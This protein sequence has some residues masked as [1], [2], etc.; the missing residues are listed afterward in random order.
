MNSNLSA[1]VLSAMAAL[2]VLLPNRTF[3]VGA[4]TCARMNDF[5]DHGCHGSPGCPGGPPSG[6]NNP[7]GNTSS[8]P[9]CPPSKPPAGNPDLAAPDGA[10]ASTGVT[11][12]P[13]WWVSEPYINL[14]IA[15]EPLSYRMSSG[16]DMTFR[17]TYR[18]NYMLPQP[19]QVPNWY[20]DVVE[21]SRNN[22][23]IVQPYFYGM[24]QYSGKTGYLV[25][26]TNAT[27]THNWMEFIVLWDSEW[28]NDWYA[29]RTIFTHEPYTPYTDSY[30]AMAFMPDGGT[31]Y[32]TS[33]VSGQTLNAST[34]LTDPTSQAQLQAFPTNN[35]PTPFYQ[36]TADANGTFWGTTTNG[37]KLTYPDGSVDVFGL[38]E[39]I[40][41]TESETGTGADSTAYALLTERVD[42]QGRVTQLGYKNVSY[43]NACKGNVSFHN[44]YRLAYVVDPDGR[45]NTFNYTSSQETGWQLENIQDQFGQTT[46]F[47]YEGCGS[48]QAG[49]LTGITD[50]QGNTSTFTYQSGSN[51]LISS[52]ITPYGTNDFYYE[53][54]LETDATNAYSNRCIYVTEPE[55]A[56]QLFAYIHNTEGA[57]EASATAPVVPG[58]VFD[59]GNGSG[60]D[61]QLY[62]RNSFYFDRRQTQ[63][64]S[65]SITG[66]LPGNLTAAVAALSAS[67]ADLKKG[68]MQ[69]WLLGT[70]NISVMETLSS[71]RDPSPDAEG[72]TE[73]ERTWYAYQDIDTDTYYS[74][75]I[76]AIAR[77]LPNGSNQYIRY[78]Y[79]PSAPWVPTE[80]AQ[81][82]TEPNGTVGELATYFSYISPNFIDVVGISNS[83]GEYVKMG[84]NGSHE[85]TSVTNSLN[86]VTQLSYDSTSKNLTGV[87][88]YS[89]ASIGLTYSDAFLSQISIQPENKAINF[90]S[91][92]GPNPSV[93]HV[94]ANGVP[95]L[96][97]TN[98]WDNLNRVTGIG[99]PDGTT[100][101]NVY[102]IL[103]LGAH[104]DRLGNWTYYTHDGLQHL[105]TVTNALTNVTTYTWCDCGALTSIS[106]ALGNV[107]TF[108]YNNQSLLTN[109][110]YADGSSLNWQYDLI[111]RMTNE[112]DGSGSY[113]DLSY[114]NQGL[115]T[116]VSNPIGLV[117]GAALDAIGRPLMV[118]NV[119]GVVH[120]NTFDLLN[121]ILTRSWTGG[122]TES[123]G[124]ATNGLVA[125]TNQDSQWT[126]FGRDGAERPTAMTNVVQTTLLGWNGLD[127][128]SSL[129]DG[130]N[131]TTSWGYN[132]YGWIIGKTNTFGTAVITYRE[133]ADGHVTNRWMMGTNTAYKFDAVGNLTGVGYPA[134]S[135]T[136]QYDSINELT[137]LTDSFGTTAFTWTKNRQLAG[138]SGP[139]PSDGIAY[140]YSQGH[141]I[142]LS[143]SQPV[144]NWTQSYNYDSAWRMTNI[145][146]PAG[147]F[148][149]QYSSAGQDLVS[150]V[151][152]P[153]A[154]L[155]ANSYDVLGR[156]TGTSLV[157]SWG[158]TLDGY[159]YGIDA[160]GLRTNIT[161]DLGM[162]TNI[163]SANYD[164][165]GQLTGWNGQE[166][167]GALRHNEQLGY[168]IDAAGNIHNRTNDVFLQVFNAD[169]Q[170]QLT[171]VSYSGTLTYSGATPAP[172]TNI[173]INGVTAQL[174]GDLTFAAPG[175]TLNNGGNTFTAL[176][177]NVY[178]LTVTNTVVAT[179]SNSVNLQ[180]DANGNLTNDGLRA[181]Q[182]NAENQ[183]T[184]VWVAGQ[185][186]VGFIYDG[187]RRRRIE[188]DSTWSGS[189]V[190]TNEI[191]YVY[192]GNVVIQERDTNSNPVAAYTR[193]LDLS[194]S[195]QGAG[196]VGGLL[197]RTETNGSYFF[198]AD[199]GGNITAMLDADQNVVTR[200]EY[201]G[202]GRFLG[203]WGRMA[204]T[205]RYRFSSKEIIPQAGIY[206]YGYRFYDPNFGRW[207]NRDPIGE[208]GD[209]NL[210]NFS[211]NSPVSGFDI[212]GLWYSGP[213]INAA[214][215]AAEEEALGGGP[216]DPVADV[217]ALG[218]LAIGLATAALTTSFDPGS[219][220]ATQP[221]NSATSPPAPQA[222]PAS[223]QPPNKPPC[224]PKKGPPG[225]PGDEP[226]NHH[227]LPQQF[228]PW[229]NARGLNPE[230]YTQ[231]MPMQWHRGEDIGIHN[232]GYNAD[233]QSFIQQYPDA[234]PQQILQQLNY[235]ENHYGF[236]P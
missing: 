113:L 179:Y 210:Y 81:S 28:E 36:G 65:S 158:H 52:L 63:A 82:V 69:H 87:S 51:G 100:V 223:A 203:M 159:G 101:S 138:E 19:D 79:S 89:G 86:Q 140:G 47:S 132:Q 202:F 112:F 129:T 190:K 119:N 114:D 62:H 78:V 115:V 31:Y 208:R 135:I 104:K 175:L 170:N 14:H 142:S 201:D 92:A 127:E 234:T 177:Q 198:H 42:P 7:G 34:Q 233:W 213:L 224:P 226:E 74:D 22:E 150:G 102:A 30:E 23:V 40:G 131:H 45:T 197:A 153:N 97:Q 209:F 95:D 204:S 128:L 121:H 123:F 161:R 187:L 229:F 173:T 192:D 6:Q 27:W 70:D 41:N 26:M 18:Q 90:N 182:Y 216:E 117:W 35:V 160:L 39:W 29:N 5:K 189:W 75:T 174:Y 1:L 111:G 88:T 91:Y 178:G 48:S 194:L 154:A 44:F 228:A 143:L 217:G 227:R 84:Y 12:M 124:Y 180:F 4:C 103:D 134:S 73:G 152:L 105:I 37:L 146:S 162:T 76:T 72:T 130:L 67:S 136:L 195:L 56:S 219:S 139:W 11:G 185:W 55:G 141:L 236:G 99:Y 46:T 38:T 58:S 10:D 212:N 83:V 98:S 167:G 221:Q 211:A 13:R 20:T 215:Y 2:M 49:W 171:N 122:G 230:D 137:N 186:Q 61:A 24:R 200:Y 188:Q 220:P 8:C 214:K 231:D 9:T 156:L 199:G 145:T 118:T 71:E 15:D 54:A 235:L 96:W 110:D 106:N 165:I 166:S 232:Q 181:F 183:L 77:I 157:N 207:L 93:I 218:T 53:E 126:H 193:G 64:L 94:T 16:K 108:S 155:I 148:G 149:Y 164:G 169:P 151:T 120:S 33:D 225:F 206:Y 32:F 184:N 205:N 21:K 176:A 163:V 80:N 222:Q 168:A 25:G 133:D 116:T 60:T 68:R 172:A 125:Y 17:F 50:A 144:G 147:Y 66:N 43:T 109:V 196:G 85:A 107:T 3:A 59:D 191:H 57:V